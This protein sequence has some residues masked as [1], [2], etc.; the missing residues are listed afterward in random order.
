[1]TEKRS[2]V[3]YASLFLYAAVVGSLLLAGN[4]YLNYETQ[5]EVKIDNKLTTRSPS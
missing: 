2:N 1:M 4:E 5:W 3:Y